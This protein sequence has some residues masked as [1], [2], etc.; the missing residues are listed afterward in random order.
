VKP[1][2]LDDAPYE[3]R[4]EEMGEFRDENCVDGVAARAFVILEAVPI[5]AACGVDLFKVRIREHREARQGGAGVEEDG[6]EAKVH[7]GSVE[8]L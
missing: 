3:L 1:V 6:V 2:K 5:K 8:R 7:P 4:R